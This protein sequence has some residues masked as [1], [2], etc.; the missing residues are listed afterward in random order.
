MKCSGRV[1]QRVN[2]LA[3]L[4]NNEQVFEFDR[5][6]AFDEEKLAFFDRMDADMDKGIRIHGELIVAP[7][8]KQRARFVVMNLIKALQQ[9]NQAVISVSCA[10]LLHRF[11]ALI[12]IQANDNGD[13]IN[14]ELVEE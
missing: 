4:V 8:S 5:D 11:P 2:K 12:E 1:C 14:I 9:D 7:D 13:S 3:V 10:F 6:L